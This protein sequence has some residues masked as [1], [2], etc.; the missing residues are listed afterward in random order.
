LRIIV[1]DSN[2]NAGLGKEANR[3]GPVAI[4]LKVESLNFNHLFYFWV[5]ARSGSIAKACE[6]LLLTPQT[7]SAQIKVLESSL[8]EKLF[9]RSRRSL[10]LTEAGHHVKL[11][12]DEMFRIGNDLVKSLRGD[13]HPL[14]AR[15]SVGV[16]ETFPKSITHKLLE[17]VIDGGGP[18]QY[19][20]RENRLGR[21]L[22]DMAEFRLDLILATGPVPATS[23][24]KAFN[25]RLSQ[26][27]MAFMAVPK[28]AARF[29]RKFPSSLDGA[30][31]LLPGVDSTLRRSLDQWFD[32]QGIRPRLVGE[33]EDRALL[34]DFGQAGK[35]IFA[36]PRAI[37]KDAARQY[38]VRKVGD[39]KGVVESYYAISMEKR[40]KNPFV[41]RVRQAAR[42]GVFQ[43]GLNPQKS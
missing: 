39:V 18:V 24:I 2:S 12:A 6:Q 7:I 15:V 1:T 20:F 35:G 40:I 41:V 32:D 5:V 10:Q 28:L 16:T 4:P 23:R 30:P 27:G 36:V 8:G 13:A 43:K 3:A 14:T 25:H 37:E 19:S 42:K 38:K 26:S 21:L 33:F 11:Y 34:E 29:R 31:F 22:E 9:S 17:P